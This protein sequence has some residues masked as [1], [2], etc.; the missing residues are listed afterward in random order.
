MDKTV[1]ENQI[2]LGTQSECCQD[3]NLDSKFSL[4]HSTYYEKETMFIPI[5]LRNSTSHKH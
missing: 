1:A 5:D 2:F 3:S 4:C